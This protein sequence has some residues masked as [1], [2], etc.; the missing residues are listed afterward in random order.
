MQRSHTKF[1]HIDN[2]GTAFVTG[3]PDKCQH[4][5]NGSCFF[6]GNG[7][8]LYEKNYRCPTDEETYRY[9][10]K[11]AEDRNTYV[12]GGSVCCSKCGSYIT[13]HDIIMSGD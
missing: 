4:D 7:D 10:T 12:C 2:I 8:I 13:E 5:D 3:I 1:I 11:I 9:I 6:L